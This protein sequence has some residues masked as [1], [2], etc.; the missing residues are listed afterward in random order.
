MIGT[1]IS[2]D[3]ILENLGGGGIPSEHAADTPSSSRSALEFFSGFGDFAPLLIGVTGHRDLRS[4]DDDALR[5]EV[6]L[7]FSRLQ[8][9]WEPSAPSAPIVLLTALAKGADQL[10][11]EI[12]FNKGIPVIAVLPLPLKSYEDDFADPADL[13]AFRKLLRQSSAVVTVPSSGSNVESRLDRARYYKTAGAYIV[14][15]CAVLIALWDGVEENKPGGTSDV[16]RMKLHGV[17]PTAQSG[18]N[19][20]ELASV[21]PVYQIVTPRQS[22]TELPEIRLQVLHPDG[23][24]TV[25][26]AAKPEL[27]DQATRFLIAGLRRF[28]GDWSKL[29]KLLASRMHES[30]QEILPSVTVTNDIAYLRRSYAVADVMARYFQK[31]ST[32]TVRCY[33]WLL[34]LAGLLLGTIFNFYYSDFGRDGFVIG[35]LAVMVTVWCLYVFSNTRQFHNRYH[36]YRALAEALRIQLFW[37]VAGIDESVGGYYPNCQAGELGWVHRALRAA[38]LPIEGP[39]GGNVELVE[40]QWVRGQLSFYHKAEK[41]DGRY[42]RRLSL[43]GTLALWVAVPWAVLR[44]LARSDGQVKGGLDLGTRAFYLPVPPDA[45]AFLLSTLCVILATM[46]ALALA[47]F[48]YN[49]LRGFSEH[50]K[51]YSGMIPLF[52]YS[53]LALSKSRDCGSQQRILLHLGREALAENAYWL[54]MHHER[55][56]DLP[57]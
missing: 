15:H 35:Y 5:R 52:E 45:P 27:L 4:E 12:A 51:R 18:E 50:A 20:F 48:G 19:I 28:N 13:H 37:R 24:A 26:G 49:H 34:L 32:R 1:A 14:R 43:W 2:H 38:S 41:R 9:E 25:I 23:K 17:H 39:R 8:A 21:G 11:A 22:S 7:L 3:R 6:E 31:L 40:E 54:L 57:R 29:R 30:E 10:V 47:L 33:F 42:A 16:V 44:V 53:S 36:E 55:K 56:F 46:S